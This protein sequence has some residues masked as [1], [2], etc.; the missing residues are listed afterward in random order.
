MP[1][2][3]SLTSRTAS[4]L[5]DGG[6]LQAQTHTALGGVRHPDTFHGITATCTVFMYEYSCLWAKVMQRYPQAV[7]ELLQKLGRLC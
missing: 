1:T 4:N 5:G 6:L 2:S 7:R 3:L